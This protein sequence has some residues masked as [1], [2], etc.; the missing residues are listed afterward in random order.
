MSLSRD[1]SRR[2]VLKALGAAAA[3]AGASIA[4]RALGMPSS[5]APPRAVTEG[6]PMPETTATPLAA[7]DPTASPAP[8]SS[9]GRVAFVNTTDRAEGVRRAL[10]LLELETL[11]GKSV[12]LKPNFN[13]ADPAPGSSHPDVLRALSEWLWQAGASAVTIGDRSGMGDT[14]RVM[15]Q[16][17]VFDLA[18]ELRLE[19]MV[20]DELGADDWVMQ[21][22]PGSHWSRGFAIARPVVEA[23]AVVQACCLKTHRY[24][25]HFTLSLKNSVG[26][27]AGHVPGENYAYM[28]ELH[29][30]QHQRAMIAEINTAYKPTA[31]VLDGVEAFVTGGP[32]SGKKVQAS[33]VLAAVDRVAIDAVGVALLRY[34][35]TTPEV[36]SGPVFG[37]EQIARA[38]ELGLG[39]A[40]PE[41][42]AFLTDDAE[43][44]AY[45]EALRPILSAS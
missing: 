30:S 6:T 22:V 11:T 5:A 40:S 15:E 4:C 9:L 44:A 24:G 3:A 36:R 23:D 21:D 37:Q 31:V 13:S 26:M 32:D 12:L 16:L 8:A 14:R 29:S 34:Y 27:I 25:G 41:G 1:L 18:E 42:I 45:A 43:S 35:G 33:V 10:A 38:V 39:V 17:G 20:F 7:L 2:H 19:T 28:D